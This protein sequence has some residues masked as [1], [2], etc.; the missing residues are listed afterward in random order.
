MLDLDD[1]GEAVTALPPPVWKRNERGLET[2]RR[3][4][5]VEGVEHAWIPEGGSYATRLYAERSWHSATATCF[6]IDGSQFSTTTDL[7]REVEPG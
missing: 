4:M 6:E 3:I 5:S 1:D 7:Y 2:F